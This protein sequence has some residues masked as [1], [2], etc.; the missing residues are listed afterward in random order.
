MMADGVRRHPGGRGRVGGLVPVVRGRDALRAGPA[1]AAGAG[2]AVFLAHLDR[3]HDIHRI[4]DT[5]NGGEFGLRSN[6][7]LPLSDSF[8]LHMADERAPRLVNDVPAHPV[9]GR[10][11]AQRAR[12]AAR[13][14]ACRSSS[15]T[16]RASARWRR[17]R[18]R[19]P[20]PARPRA[21]VRDARARARLRARARDQRARPAPPE[22]L[23]AHPGARHGRGQRARP[24]AGRRRGRPPGD[25]ARRPPRPPG[26]RSHSCSSRPGRELVSTAMYGVEMPPVT[27]QAR[28]DRARATRRRS[29]A[30]SYF[31]ADA[32]DHPALAAAARGGHRRALRAVRAGRPRGRRRRRDDPDLARRRGAPSDSLDA[33]LR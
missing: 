21:A 26:R 7:A 18:A 11:A 1:R 4:V 27:I 10:V 28:E 33:V 5:R 25:P 8:G 29:L 17:C 12:G 20:L 2:V 30:E 24:R 9:Y 3:G 6:L 16:A 23:A 22:R 14:S 13:T 32:R 19:R 31:V 15:P